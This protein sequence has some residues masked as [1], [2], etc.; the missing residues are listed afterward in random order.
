MPEFTSWDA[1][2][3]VL[4]G[5]HLEHFGVRGM[6]WGQRRY[7]YSDGSLTPLGRERYGNNGERSRLG[8][9]HD[10][11]KLDREQTNA[12]ARYDYLHGKGTVAVARARK[13]LRKAIEKGNAAKATKQRAKIDKIKRTTLEKAKQ[14]KQ[15]LSKSRDM[16]ERII[17]SARAKGYSIKSRDCQRSVNRGRNAGASIAANLAAIPVAALTGVSVYTAFNEYATGKHYRV[18]NDGLGTRTHRSR[19]FGKKHN[20]L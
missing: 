15:L 3:H 10:L 11:N 9:K 6:K 8:I 4:D 16:T 5:E 14:Y 12:K 7:Q 17:K 13:K 2:L 20:G 1:G 19:R 18:V